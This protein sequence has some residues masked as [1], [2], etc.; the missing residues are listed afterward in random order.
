[1]FTFHPCFSNICRAVSAFMPVAFGTGMV[2]GGVYWP[3]MT[4][5]IEPGARGV[6]TATFWPMTTP[7]R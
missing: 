3:T 2:A 4:G 7:F 6:P 5:T 1:M